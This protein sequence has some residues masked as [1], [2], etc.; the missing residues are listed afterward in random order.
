MLCHR[1]LITALYH[2][3]VGWLWFSI[4]VLLLPWEISL[5]YEFI[6]VDQVCFQIIDHEYWVI[7][8]TKTDHVVLPLRM[9]CKMIELEVW[10]LPYSRF[11][12]CLVFYMETCFRIYFSLE[13]I[14]CYMGFNC[15]KAWFPWGKSTFK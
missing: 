8:F 14:I 7:L 12:F 5:C 10:Y 9:D 4:G 2:H 11:V 6:L 1:I 13:H 3:L 15:Q